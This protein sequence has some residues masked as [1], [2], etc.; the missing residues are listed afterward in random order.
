MTMSEFLKA[1]PLL[2]AL[3]LG[4]LTSLSPCPLATNIAAVSFIA[5]QL[6]SSRA[7]L[8]SGLLYALGRTVTYTS[9]GAVVCSGVASAP[10]V[11]HFLQHKLPQV[12]GPILILVG[13][14]LLDIFKIPL[15]SA[16][17]GGTAER[18]SK[19]GVFSSLPLGVLFALA[20][21]PVSAALFFGAL[22]PLSLHSGSHILPPAVF[23][24]GTALPV[25]AVAFGLA[26]GLQSLFNLLESVGRVEAIAR[27]ITGIVF[28]AVGFY[29]TLI[30]IFRVL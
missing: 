10:F 6:T 9:L 14:F 1:I 2:T 20:F 26:F 5:H 4:I 3:W 25:V 27:K 30:Y 19:G 23:G 7:V 24:V 8:L 13:A 28:I 11:S 21:C 17:L 18:L 16:N 22:I 12:L 29:Y 15:P